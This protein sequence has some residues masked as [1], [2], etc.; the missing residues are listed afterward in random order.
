M[1]LGAGL[2][3]ATGSV[4]RWWAFSVWKHRCGAEVESGLP[5][6]RALDACPLGRPGDILTGHEFH[7]ASVL[8]SPDAPLFKLQD[9]G[10]A[11]T[12]ARR[13]A[14]RGMSPGRFFTLL[15]VAGASC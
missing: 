8:T 3:D 6:S 7:Y 15:T 12:C 2:V 13:R 1:T 5:Q 14:S 4:T 11:D 9:L 10:W